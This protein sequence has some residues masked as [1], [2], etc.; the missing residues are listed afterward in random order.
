[1]GAS[2]FS[3]LEY[4]VY[5]AFTAFGRLNISR[6]HELFAAISSGDGGNMGIKYPPRGLPMDLS[7]DSQEL[8]FTETTEV[9]EFLEIS[10][11]EDEEETSLEEYAEGFGDWA[12]RGYQTIG[13][14]PIPET[15]NHSW[16]NLN[17]LKAALLS[18]NLRLDQQSADFRALMAAMETLAEEYG[19]EKVRL[20]FCFG[21]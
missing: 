7:L 10:R 1:M 21:L 4:E 17:E 8:F 13:H 2:F 19:P 14:L 3:V 5:G 12:V 9:K 11:A 6:D 18:R 20:V 15:Y 16:L